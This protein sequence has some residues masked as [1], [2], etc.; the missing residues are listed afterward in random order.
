MIIHHYPQHNIRSMHINMRVEKE[1]P[2]PSLV[3]D[4][5]LVKEI[6]KEDHI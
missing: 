4:V 5:S 2:R 6:C 1:I 3:S